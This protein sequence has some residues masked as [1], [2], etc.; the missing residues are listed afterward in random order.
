MNINT[1]SK[2]I[3]KEVFE[4][5]GHTYYQWYNHLNITEIILDRGILIASSNHFSY[6]V[7]LL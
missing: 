2:L 5:N 3:F 4:N 6:L 7:L 1:D